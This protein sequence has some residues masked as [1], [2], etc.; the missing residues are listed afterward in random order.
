MRTLVKILIFFAILGAI[1]GLAWPP[2]SRY[3]AERS[4][5]KWRLAKTAQG[6]VKSVV[7]STGT[8]KPVILIS[9][10][11]FVSGPILKLAA[12]FNQEVAEK[13][14]LAEI[15]PRIYQAAVDRE[16]AN[17]ATRRADVARAKAQLQ[18]AINDEKRANALRAE[19][20]TF[21]AQAEL[22]K[23]H[24]AMLSLKAQVE[25][26]EAAVDQARAGL[27]N[28]EAQ[29]AYTK[30]EAPVSGIIISRKIDPGQTLAAQFQTPELFTIAPQMRE[31]MHIHAAVDEADIGLIRSAQQ[32]GLPV[33]FTVDAYPDDLFEGRIEEIRLS[34]TTTQNVV[35]YPVIVSAANPELKL[36]PGMTASISFQVD[37]REN[38]V[39]I[40]NAAL[41]YFPDPKF[42]READ[43]KLLEG[44]ADT[45]Q[46]QGSD[47]PVER[48]LSAD[49]RAE[50]RRKRS[51]RHV[52]VVDG[53][54]LR[55]IPVATGISD[56]H[57]TEL[58]EGDL[59][60]DQELVTGILPK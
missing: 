6:D 16:L 49:E 8:V 35:T 46:S 10:G 2:V 17:L 52:W 41:R 37:R 5:P 4:R 1:G 19:D 45:P 33:S 13:Q 57:F 30:I 60:P 15:D 7:N 56:S 38:V 58:V 23:Y 14:I 36:L 18:Q 25:V 31:K 42:V 53:L 59:K 48:A 40:P 43:R 12:E 3:L 44:T 26:A 22:D 21:I 28:A 34:S 20:P 11:S 55:A 47:E 54:Q 24:F 27:E 39:K 32:V 51:R 29:L 50:T 9:V